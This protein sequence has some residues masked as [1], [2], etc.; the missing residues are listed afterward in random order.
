MNDWIDNQFIL[1]WQEGGLSD[2]EV[3]KRKTVTML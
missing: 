1:A 2:K 3:N